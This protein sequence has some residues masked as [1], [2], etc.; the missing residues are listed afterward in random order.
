MSTAETLQFETRERAI[1]RA[2]RRLEHLV[3]E[4]G[5]V[6]LVDRNDNARFDERRDQGERLSYRLGQSGAPIHHN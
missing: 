2:S 6:E 3:L 1:Q 5:E 4:A